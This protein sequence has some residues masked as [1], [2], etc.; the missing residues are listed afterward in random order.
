MTWIDWIILGIMFVGLYSVGMYCRQYAKSVLTFLAAGRCARRYVMAVSQGIAHFGAIGTVAAFELTYNGGLTPTYWGM[1][2]IVASILLAISGFCVYR[3][4]E[5]RVLTVGQLIEERYSR[6]L[7]IFMGITA[8]TAGILNFGLFPAV[9][10]RFFIFYC[11]LPAWNFHFCGIEFSLMYILLM[12]G[13]LGTV[14]FL[15]FIGGQISVMVTDFLQGIFCNFITLILSIAL[16]V[17]FKWNDILAVLTANST[18]GHSLINPFQSAHTSDFNVWYYLIVFFGIFYTAGSGGGAQCT[19]SA[20][21][22]AHEAQMGAILANIRGMTLIALVLLVP[23]VYT[24]MHHPAY[25]ADAAAVQGILANISDPVLRSQHTVSVVIS[26]I[27]PPGLLGIF[28]CLM[29]VAFVANH[30]TYMHNWGSVFIQDVIMPFRTRPFTPAQHV[31]YLKIS[32]LGVAVFIFFFSL[33]YQQNEQIL[34]FFAMTGAIFFSGAGIV[35][36]GALYWNRGTTAAAWSALLI[37][38]GFTIAGAIA[39]RIWPGFP[40]HSMYLYFIGC[41][42]CIVTFI[43]VSLLG[44]TRFNLDRLLHRNKYQVKTDEMFEE[45]VKIATWQRRLGITGHFSTGD[46]VIYLGSIA[47]TALMA[48][49]FLLVM[50]INFVIPLNDS[51]WSAYWWGYIIAFIALNLFVA[52]WFVICGYGDFIDLFR[53]LKKLKVDTQDDGWI[54]AKEAV[55]LSDKS[56]VDN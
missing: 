36:L 29:T 32:I 9:G 48:L 33:L 21:L 28:A 54:S 6:K 41:L 7:R 49:T 39:R 34:M 51:F 38:M 55:E 50:T 31:K 4:R 27:L 20:A 56:E 22:N 44:K 17:M 12:L 18:P 46:K 19:Q 11:G 37:G 23:V 13:L 24:F 47:W 8:W 16:L 40:I 5:T 3:M 15:I 10:T 2:Q 42:L 14:L 43:V 45:Q 26:H 53:Q 30:D 1:L 35:T 52:F 25:A